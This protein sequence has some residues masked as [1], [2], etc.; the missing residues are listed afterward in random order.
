MALRILHPSHG[1]ITI[2]HEDCTFST[3]DVFS[4]AINFS[5]ARSAIVSSFGTAA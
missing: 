4:V 2:L 3:C 1:L 5:C